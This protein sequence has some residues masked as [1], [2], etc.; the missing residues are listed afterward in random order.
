M[1]VAEVTNPAPRL[2]DQAEK[3][4]QLVSFFIKQDEFAVDISRVQEINK[5]AAIAHVPRAPKFVEGVINLRGHIVPVINLRE[6]FGLEKIGLTKSTRIIV[7]NI[8]NRQVGLIVDSVSEVKR[9][10]CSEIKDPPS[11]AV[12][13]AADFVTG[14]ANVNG[15][16]LII[17]DLHKILNSQEMHTIEAIKKSATDSQLHSETNGSLK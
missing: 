10:N 17:L 7:I 8:D 6:R 3:T 11:E 13:D 2:A 14:I 16:L 4:T 1:S 5:M 15:R 9:V 12:G